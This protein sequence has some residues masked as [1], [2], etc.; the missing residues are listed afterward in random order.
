MIICADTGLIFSNPKPYL[1]SRQA[2]HPTLVPLDNG[3]LLCS[4]DVGEGVES[5][6]YRTYHS[7][8]RDG[9]KTWVEQGHL[10]DDTVNSPTSSLVRLTKL[11]DGNLVGFGSRFHR[12]D[13]EEGI[14]SRETLGF[15]PLDLFT[16][17]S[18]D[19]GRSWTEPTNF[20][21]PVENPAFEICHSIVELPDGTWLL[22]TATAKGWDGSLP[23]GQQSLVFI[24]KDQGAS[25]DSFG[26]T[27]EQPDI[28]Y[29]E[30]SLVR[31]DDDR[32]IVA[33]WAHNLETGENQP[34]PFAIS[35]DS[36]RSF[37]KPILTGFEGQT[38]K[39][40]SLGNNKIL[41]VYR[42]NDKPGLW[43][44]LSQ[45]DGDTWTNL[46]DLALWGSGMQ[47]SGMAGKDNTYD[48]LSG[49]HF[50]YPT[51]LRTSPTSVLLAF[52][53]LEGWTCNIRWFKLDIPSLKKR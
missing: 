29:W 7:R 47:T 13:P 19:G 27:F 30:Q 45:I 4:Y 51:L 33:A 20:S 18:T 17:T 26:V 48:E 43:A 2:F 1:K 42:R 50:G 36:G 32:L 49:L 44:T 22:P 3:E 31:L 39:L 28:V 37:S 25:W 40:L 6:D 5:L 12:E 52:W 21:P 38:C 41:C 24:S 53:C 8:S 9:G 46:S 15:V 10:F 16:I 35:S 11:N 14:V 23:A 34:T